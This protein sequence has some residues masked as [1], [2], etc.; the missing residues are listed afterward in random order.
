MIFSLFFPNW[1]ILM[2]DS[3]WRLRYRLNSISMIISMIIS[4]RFRQLRRNDDPLFF[5]IADFYFFLF[6]RGFLVL[7][8][9]FVLLVTY[10]I[11]LLIRLFLEFRRRKF[12]FLVMIILFLVVFSFFFRLIVI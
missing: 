9:S 8:F 4:I 12:I 5:I 10:S 2:L 1:M 11:S 7:D 3:F 6:R